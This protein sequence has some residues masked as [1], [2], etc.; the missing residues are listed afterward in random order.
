MIPQSNQKSIFSLGHNN[1]YSKEKEEQDNN[2]NMNQNYYY[3]YRP[4]ALLKGCS[5]FGFFLFI[6]YSLLLLII[7]SYVTEKENN[8]IRISNKITYPMFKSDVLS[9]LSNSSSIYR[10]SSTYSTDQQMNQVRSQIYMNWFKI[11]DSMGCGK[12]I[13]I[14]ETMNASTTF[15]LE[16]KSPVCHCITSS[17]LVITYDFYIYITR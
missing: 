10:V 14:L 16:I 2:N 4:E 17:F 15:V 1:N 12:D 3:Y 13:Q 6:L 7:S 11:S 9:A 8:I 5:I